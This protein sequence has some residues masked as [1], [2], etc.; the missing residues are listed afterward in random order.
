MKT[1]SLRTSTFVFSG[2]AKVIG[3]Y[4]IFT[5]VQVRLVIVFRINYFLGAACNLLHIIGPGCETSSSEDP[6]LSEIRRRRFWACY[7]AHVHSSD[8]VHRFSPATDLD[9]LTLP[10]PEDDFEAGISRQPRV[11]IRSTK[12]NGGL[13]P[14]VIKILNLW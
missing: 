8:C 12:S 10:W 9:T 6:L 7:Q 14:E 1:I 3:E 5:K 11:T 2:T 13:Y 4:A